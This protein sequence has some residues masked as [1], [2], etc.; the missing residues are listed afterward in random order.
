[1][2]RAAYNHGYIMQPHMLVHMV[3]GFVIISAA[4]RLGRVCV[5]VCYLLQVNLIRHFTH[6]WYKQEEFT[7]DDVLNNYFSTFVGIT[8]IKQRCATRL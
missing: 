1:M 4:V 8:A 3:Q 2:E 5:C 7:E 6:T